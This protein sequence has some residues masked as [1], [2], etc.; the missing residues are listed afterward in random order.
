[1]HKNVKLMFCSVCLTSSIALGDGF[2]QGTIWWVAGQKYGL[3]PELLYS[4][5]L[6][7]SKL[8]GDGDKF[9]VKAWPWTLRV[10][11]KAY[12]YNNKE[13]TVKALEQFVSE[14]V[15][16]WRIDVGMMQ[17][18]LK[19]TYE[20]RGYDT[21][22]SLADLVEP[23]IN[24]GIAAKILQESTAATG[25]SAFSVGYYHNIAEPRRSKYGSEV[26]NTMRLVKLGGAHKEYGVQW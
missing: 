25:V 26:V 6:V 22:Y 23:T 8:A 9:S 21:I 10:D 20:K 11:P 4:V 7:E 12:R 17:L 5:A 15:E 1:M 18:N 13:E 2:G 24:V 3:E 16:S 14:G 19:W